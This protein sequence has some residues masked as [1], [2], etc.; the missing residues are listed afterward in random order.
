MTYT[1]EMIKNGERE[2]IWSKY[3]GYL[4]LSIEEY[5]QIQERLLIEQLAT[6]KDCN[7]GKHFF[8]KR[9]PKSVEEFRK[10][11]PLTTYADYVDFLMDQKEDDL[12]K[13]N[14]RWA[15]T[16]GRSG[17]YACKWVPLTDSMYDSTANTRFSKMV[18]T[19]FP[20]G[21]CFQC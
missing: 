5:M 17:E 8:G 9:P 3:C 21:R 19:F 20:L 15:C 1:S 10:N 4:D 11:V 16:S 2:K 7:P 14:Y 18:G 6:L 12:P 13:A